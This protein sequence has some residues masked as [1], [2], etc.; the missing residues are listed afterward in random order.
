MVLDSISFET[1]VQSFKMP[2]ENNFFL[3][4]S[5]CRA[6]V[7]SI[8]SNPY[9]T[10]FKTSISNCVVKLIV[11]IFLGLLVFPIG[12]LL[13]FNLRGKTFKKGITSEKTW[14][15]ILM[16][17]IDLILFEMNFF[18]G[19]IMSNLGLEIDLSEI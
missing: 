19:G 7:Q 13:I 14:I 17:F 4:W 3:Q 11:Q 6:Q 12:Y 18:V 9:Q 8:E 10:Y 1:F 5:F 16:L 15:L 2:D